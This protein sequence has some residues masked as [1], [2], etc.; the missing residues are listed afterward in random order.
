VRAILPVPGGEITGL[1]FGGINFDT[2]YVSCIDHK[3]YRRK[4]KVLGAP[5]WGA[6]IQLPSWS[7]G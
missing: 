6:P 7:P 1:S 3:L 5:S 2:L 4:L